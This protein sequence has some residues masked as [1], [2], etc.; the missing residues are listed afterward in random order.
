MPVIIEDEV[1]LGV[2]A[3][4]YEERCESAAR[5]LGSGTILNASTAVYDVVRGEIYERVGMSRWCSRASGGGA[6][7]AQRSLLVR[8]DGLSLPR[9]PHCE[10][11][12]FKDDRKLADDLRDKSSVA[13]GLFPKGFFENRA[14]RCC[15]SFCGKPA[16]GQQFLSARRI[17][18]ASRIWKYRT[19]D[20]ATSA[21]RNVGA[22]YRE[23]R[24]P[25]PPAPGIRSPQMWTGRCQPASPAKQ[26]IQLLTW[27]HP[28][29]FTDS[30]ASS[31]IPAPNPI[32]M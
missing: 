3:V 17:S 31:S 28:V 8:R 15:A 23:L 7:V 4:V 13:R 21:D 6:G 12:R 25:S 27:F 16:R 26:F 9:T 20:P 10:V 30:P 14:A 2:T 11:S 22:G 5:W 29:I 24:R 19:V 32:T 18:S 1:L